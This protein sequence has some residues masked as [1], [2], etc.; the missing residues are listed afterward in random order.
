MKINNI[1]ILVVLIAFTSC[2]EWLDV[3]PIEDIDATD[4]I[5]TAEGIRE[6]LNGAYIGASQDFLYGDALSF[7]LIEQV[8]GNQYVGSGDAH[9]NLHNYNDIS[10][11]GVTDNI[12][13]NAYKVIGN[14]NYLLDNID[15]KKGL[16]SESEYLN[17][18]AEAVAMR[19]F[20][21]FDLLRCFAQNYEDAPEAKAIPYVDVFEKRLFLHNTATE[22]VDK[23]LAELSYAETVLL[24]VDPIVDLP[25]SALQTGNQSGNEINEFVER[26]FR[27]NYYAVLA[28][29]AR[30]Y[31]YIGEKEQASLYA[32]KVIDEFPFEWTVFTE[33]SEND[34]VMFSESLFVFDVYNLYSKAANKFGSVGYTGGDAENEYCKL[35]I[36]DTRSGGVG[37]SDVRFTNCFTYDKN[38]LQNVPTKYNYESVAGVPQIKI[39]EMM[40]ILAENMLET[41]KE[42]AVVL[43]NQIRTNRLVLLLSE[44]SSVEEVKSA[45]IDEFRKETYLEGQFFYLNKRLK[46]DVLPALYD[47]LTVG[48]E[49]YTFPLPQ[50]EIEFGDGARI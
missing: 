45:I 21:H 37:P 22:V 24:D 29:K 28:I 1:L 10:K 2:S 35:K 44:S 48:M 25:Y 33:G 32:Q 12:F 30:V 14:L 40:L 19:A 13:L 47:D 34:K 20:L 26:K 36:F 38:G 43:L 49:V 42:G 31:Q 18:K 7:G 4:Q 5:N 46:T 41:N 8:G 17:I 11:Y 9:K 27:L 15:E 6:I 3:K 23:V 16:F 39:S 50:N